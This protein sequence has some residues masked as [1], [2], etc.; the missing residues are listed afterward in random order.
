M[1]QP[2]C[3]LPQY[4]RAGLSEALF[5]KKC[6]ICYD[7][8]AT[9]SLNEEQIYVL[10]N[11]LY[12]SLP[13]WTQCKLGRLLPILILFSNI[14][15]LYDRLTAKISQT[16]EEDF[17]NQVTEFVKNIYMKKTQATVVP[18]ELPKVS[19]GSPLKVCHLKAVHL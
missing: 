2:S 6:D 19:D 3:H 4:N 16:P 8:F 1:E 12:S 15:F 17:E 14:R 9:T 13:S 5:I 18:R 11:M 10:S 7:M